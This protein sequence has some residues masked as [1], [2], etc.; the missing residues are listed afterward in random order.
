MND[1]WTWHRKR[2]RLLSHQNQMD[3]CGLLSLPSHAFDNVNLKQIFSEHF[4][5][6]TIDFT[7]TVKVAPLSE[8]DAP[9]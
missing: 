3:R 4:D 8:E 9:F 7:Q 6:P 2:I 1:S 5:A